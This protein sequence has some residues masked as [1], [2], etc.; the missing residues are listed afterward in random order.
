MA[1]QH[2]HTSSKGSPYK[3]L[4]ELEQTIQNNYSATILNLSKAILTEVNKEVKSL[5]NSEII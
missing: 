2:N 4:N 3:L 5:K 1:D